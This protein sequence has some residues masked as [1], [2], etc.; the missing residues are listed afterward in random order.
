MNVASRLES[1][2]PARGIHVSHAMAERL[3]E[4]FHLEPRGEIDIKGIGEIETYFL[5]APKAA[6]S[7]G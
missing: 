7:P 6:P 3:A 1:T 5:T 4:G 2:S